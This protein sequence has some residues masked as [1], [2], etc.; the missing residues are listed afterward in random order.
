MILI[1]LIFGLAA[2][3]CY[4]LNKRDDFEF[5]IYAW[6]VFSGV[7]LLITIIMN[8]AACYDNIDDQE[9]IRASYQTEKVYT[10]KRDNLLQQYNILL[11]STYRTYETNLFDKMTNKTKKSQVNVNIY[12]DTKYSETLKVLTDKISELN[13]YIYDCQTKRINL[14]K[15]L[16]IRYKNPFYLN[17]FMDNPYAWMKLNFPELE[18]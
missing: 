13:E 10:E 5:A 6:S 14:F 8:V 11:D 9:S 18:Q 4:F 17:W 15:D 7:T 12:P 1:T 16:N 3:V 2:V